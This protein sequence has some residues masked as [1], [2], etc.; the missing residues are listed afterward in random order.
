[1]TTRSGGRS[2]GVYRA[3]NL[4]LH[5]G[6]DPDTVLEN[7]ALLAESLVIPPESLTL[8]EQ[9]H[10]TDVIEVGAPQLGRGAVVNSDSLSGADA[11]I[12]DVP[13]IPLVVL[14][15]DCVAVSLFDPT[16]RV[17]GLA[18]AG[19][20]GSV[21][22]IA[23]RTVAAMEGSFGCD[24]KNVIA[25][26][27]PSIGPEHYEVGQEVLEAVQAE[28]GR[29]RASGFVRED[30]DGTCYLDLWGLN[31]W[32]LASR[33]IPPSNIEL[34]DLCTACHPDRFFSYRHEDGKT[35]RF[36]ALIML[37]GSTSRAY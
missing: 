27:G 14:V 4:A 33:G 5:V 29:E 1:V 30:M 3:L 9:V 15:A 6:D 13:E 20:R 32:Q 31:A 22:R 34:S 25:G 36:G 23:E 18:H 11:L 10:G 17:I 8:A 12:T 7:R 24:P 28:F 35:G 21:G 19:W 37:H 16:R 26:L 2:G